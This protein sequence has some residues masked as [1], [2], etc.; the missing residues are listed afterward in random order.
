MGEKVQCKGA[1]NS[2]STLDVRA[3]RTDYKEGW[4]SSS[5]E[6]SDPRYTHLEKPGLV[7]PS[8]QLPSAELL[9][10]PS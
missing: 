5:H 1:R 8:W 4:C 7:A 10:Q 6:R 2:V 9:P 3:G